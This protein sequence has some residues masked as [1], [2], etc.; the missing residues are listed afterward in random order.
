MF[1]DH[2]QDIV[3]KT[4]VKCGK[5]F[6]LACGDPVDTSK[7]KASNDC[8]FHCPNLQGV[9]LGVGLAMLETK[10]AEEVE[11][12]PSSTNTDKTRKRRQTHPQAVAPQTGA[13]V[14]YADIEDDVP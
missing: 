11:S 7:Y 9:I 10:F 13:V 14:E 12:Q 5:T 4:C 1:T 3:E 6:C 2:L 8:L